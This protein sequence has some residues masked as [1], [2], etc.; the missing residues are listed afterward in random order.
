MKK[1]NEFD[2][3]CLEMAVLSAEEA[4]KLG[5]Y[6]VG[7][8]LAIDNKIIG[9]AFNEINNRKSF[10]YHAENSLIIKNGKKLAIARKDKNKI[11]SLYTTLEPCIQCLGSAVTNHIDRIIYIEKDLNGGAC[12]LKHHNIG[13]WY[14]EF[15]P[16]IINYRLNNKPSELM[17]KYFKKEILKGNIEWP[18][19]MLQLLRCDI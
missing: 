5:N 4:F 6:P 14:K 11:V 19:K 18:K 8:V 15:W 7:A 10:V 12:G 1:I 16:D 13:I 2:K 3:K 9:K 17:I